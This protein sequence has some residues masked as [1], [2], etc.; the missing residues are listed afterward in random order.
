MK[1][2]PYVALATTY[3]RVVRITL[4]CESEHVHD[5][6]WPSRWCQD[7]YQVELWEGLDALG[8]QRW[9]DHLLKLSERRATDPVTLLINALIA[10]AIHLE[11]EAEGGS[12]H[13]Q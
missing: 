3:M 6:T 8:K 2:T 11:Q 12:K 10:V 1:Q 7:N 13:A 9:S 5:E 4:E